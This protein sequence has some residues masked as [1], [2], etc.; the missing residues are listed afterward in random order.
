VQVLKEGM[1]Q[2]EKGNWRKIPVD[3]RA[4]EIGSLIHSYNTMVNRLAQM[5]ER[6]YEAEL[7]KQQS[8]LALRTQQLE[9]QRAEFQALQLQINPHF[10]YNTLETINCYAILEDS[11]EIREIVDAMAFML[12][13]ALHTNLKEITLV[14]ELN[15][16]R[17]YLIILK[18]RTDREFEI[19][20]AVPPELLLEKVVRFT[21]QPLVENAF[22][23][24]FRK[25]IT[26][27]HKIRI[28]AFHEDNYFCITVEDNG[29]GMTGE[30]LEEVRARLQESRIDERDGAERIGLMNVH[31]RIRM[32]FGCG[33]GL[34]VDSASGRGTTITIRLPK[35]ERDRY[36]GE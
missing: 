26:S 2:T 36:F 1:R 32:A 30:R 34:A 13:Y 17:N 24:G 10:L 11:R 7:D 28:N 31:R 5:I 9:R 14:N 6:V 18:H 15:H 3:G 29:L 23:H 22:E 16:I 25:M 20:V 21:L 35:E 19:D 33:Y 8:E 27:Q 4:D 12:R